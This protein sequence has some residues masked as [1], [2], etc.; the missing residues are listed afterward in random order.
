MRATRGAIFHADKGS[1]FNADWHFLKHLHDL[2]YATTDKWLSDNF[3]QIEKQS[4]L[5]MEQAYI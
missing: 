1:K 5:D 2:G 4:T 3:D